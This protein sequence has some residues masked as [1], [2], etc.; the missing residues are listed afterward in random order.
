MLFS[1]YLKY[2]WAEGNSKNLKNSKETAVRVCLD[3]RVDL[4][5][6]IMNSIEEKRVANKERVWFAV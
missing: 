3:N 6:G 5:Y 2:C 4:L 1:L